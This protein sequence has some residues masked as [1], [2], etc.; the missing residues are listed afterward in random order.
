MMS[1]YDPNYKSVPVTAK[2]GFK[3]V[4]FNPE[5]EVLFLRRSSKCSRAGGWDFPGGGIEFGEDPYVGIEREVTEE[6]QLVV[7]DV[8]V[9]N[10]ESVVDAKGEFAI[11]IGF[12]AHTNGVDPV[13]S[14]EHDG[15]GWVSREDSVNMDLP[16]MHKNILLK[17]LS[18]IR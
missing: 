4:V 13:L 6:T 2:V 14:W 7:S 15:F 16:E 17:A 11:I 18:D 1:E 8:T 9:V 10:V 5:D 3:A 12:K